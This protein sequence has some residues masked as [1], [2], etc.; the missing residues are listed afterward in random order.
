MNSFVSYGFKGAANSCSS[1]QGPFP[2]SH[3]MLD[4]QIYLILANVLKNN[5]VFS[6]RSMRHDKQ[7]RRRFICKEFIQVKSF[8]MKYFLT[9]LLLSCIGH[10][11]AQNKLDEIV[12]QQMIKEWERAK[13]Y[14]KEYL[15]AMPAD[16]YQFKA[17]DSIRNFSQQMLHLA[18]GNVTLGT[19]AASISDPDLKM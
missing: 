9:L 17:V 3:M 7:N 15:N 10:V 16:Q 6:H 4:S 5:S 8:K 14:T 1:T 12:K 2:K 11:T 19:A 18:F 13:S